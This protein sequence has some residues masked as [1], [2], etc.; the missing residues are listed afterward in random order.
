VDIVLWSEVSF[1]LCKEENM[2]YSSIASLNLLERVRKTMTPV[3][4]VLTCIAGGGIF[5]YFVA[6]YLLFAE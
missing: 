5:C 1:S 3:N 2:S 6:L 4:L